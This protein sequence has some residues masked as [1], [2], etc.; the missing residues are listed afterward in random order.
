[1]SD[2][3]SEALAWYAQQ[4]ANCRKLTPEGEEARAALDR[5]GG[6]RAM[7][8]LGVMRRSA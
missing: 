2:K 7:D 5:D 3:A 1:M 8:A 4:V 6:K